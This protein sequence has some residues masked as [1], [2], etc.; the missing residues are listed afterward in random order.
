VSRRE[1]EQNLKRFA[2][3][4]Y[5]RITDIEAM[6]DRL[7][8]RLQ[9]EVRGSTNVTTSTDFI[10][11]ALEDALLVI[12]SSTA[13]WADVIG[14]ELLAL[15]AIDRLKRE[16]SELE[17]GEAIEESLRTVDQKI[18]GINTTIEQITQRLPPDLQ[19]SSR[20]KQSGELAREHRAKWMRRQHEASQGLRLRVIAGGQWRC[21]GDVTK[22]TPEKE[23]SIEITADGADIRDDNGIVLGRAMNNSPL[24]YDEFEQALTDCFGRAV[25]PVRFVQQI[26]QRQDP[27]AL[28]RW[29]E[30]RV[31]AEPI[32]V[33]RSSRRSENRS[34][35]KA[36][37]PSGQ[38]PRK[39][40]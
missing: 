7:R 21:D 20:R 33:A 12:R 27:D 15:D 16:K 8:V 23:L 35:L 30:V 37:T 14:N 9:N 26:S 18:Q 6:V 28:I 4:A 38:T 29:Y 34:G 36:P 32:V 5:R 13:D 11:F 40:A 2:I 24:D 31:I 25:I 10:A 17:A 3:G 1:F 19:L 39:Q 22:L